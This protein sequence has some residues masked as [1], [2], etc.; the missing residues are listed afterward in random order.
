MKKSGCITIYTDASMCV[1]SGASAWAC[2]IKYGEG[3]KIEAGNAFKEGCLNSTHAELKAIANALTIVKIKLKP[4]NCYLVVVTDSQQAI[5]FISGHNPWTRIKGSKEE[6]QRKQANRQVVQAC[7][8]TVKSLIPKD[9]ELRMKK[10]KAHSNRDGKRSYVNNTVDII[11]KTH[12]RK[13]R[14]LIICAK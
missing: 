9:C 6:K 3:K 1:D 11:A 2:W 8:K 10:V 12:M 4:E 13:K 5:D 14:E 7:V